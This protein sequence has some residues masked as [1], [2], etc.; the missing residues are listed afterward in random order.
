MKVSW[1]VR[2][3]GMPVLGAERPKSTNDGWLTEC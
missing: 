1:A 3:N 2:S